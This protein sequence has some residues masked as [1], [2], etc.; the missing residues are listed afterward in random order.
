MMLLFPQVFGLTAKGVFPSVR[1]DITVEWKKENGRFVLD[2]ALPAG[3]EAQLALPRDVKQ[4]MA[5]GHNGKHYEIPA[6]TKSVAGLELS[7]VTVAV[8]VTG[9]THKLELAAR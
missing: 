7:D 3:L 5:F 4:N 6:G 2:T 8:K 9:G 1:G